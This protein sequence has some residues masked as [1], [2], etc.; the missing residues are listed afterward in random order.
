MIPVGAELAWFFAA[1]ERAGRHYFD[2]FVTPIYISQWVWP[3]KPVAGAGV[4]AQR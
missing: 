3:L 2:F 4:P 1:T